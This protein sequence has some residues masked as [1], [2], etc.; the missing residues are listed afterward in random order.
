MKP[1]VVVAGHQLPG[2]PQDP[3]ALEFTHK[4]I[5]VFDVEATRS[6]TA[7][8]LAARMRASF[9]NAKD[10]LGDFNMSNSSKVGVGEMAPWEE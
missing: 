7:S 8:Q 1:A 9:P 4:Y 6:K 2:D 10:V 3:A 5:M